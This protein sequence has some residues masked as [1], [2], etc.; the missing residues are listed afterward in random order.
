M[1]A[2]VL[3][4]HIHH[5]TDR[6]S[7]LLD[8][9]QCGTTRL[10]TIEGLD[11]PFLLIETVFTLSPDTAETIAKLIDSLGRRHTDVTVNDRPIHLD[12]LKPIIR[13]YRDSLLV[14]DPRAHCWKPRRLFMEEIDQPINY[15]L[16]YNDPC[17]QRTPSLTVT[18]RPPTDRPYWFFPCKYADAAASQIALIHPA[19][20]RA[21][22]ESALLQYDVHW[23]PRLLLDEW[24]L[25][26]WGKS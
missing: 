10:L 13:C 12:R 1:V 23:C 17:N 9:A 3:K 7:K 5:S 14:S 18:G 26:M 19:S 22:T 16:E 25:M 21:Q 4:F 2:P 6:R 20:L 15:R 24:E 8:L 11:G